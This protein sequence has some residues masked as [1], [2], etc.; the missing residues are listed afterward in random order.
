MEVD[1]KW[2]TKDYNYC[3]EHNMFYRKYCL[4]CALC[5]YDETEKQNENNS[6][7]SRGIYK[8]H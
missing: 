1:N 7:K 3:E 8:E 2:N 4:G 5:P 6:T